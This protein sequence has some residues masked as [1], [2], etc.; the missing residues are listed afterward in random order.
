MK[1]GRVSTPLFYCRSEEISSGQNEKHWRI[2]DALIP[3]TLQIFPYINTY[4][5]FNC[6]FSKRGAIHLSPYPFTIFKW[7]PRL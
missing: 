5:G 1:L 6:Y 7:V 4:K 3:H 2:E